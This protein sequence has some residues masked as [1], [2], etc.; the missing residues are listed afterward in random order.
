MV[1]K[2]KREKKYLQVVVENWWWYEEIGWNGW[3]ENGSSKSLPPKI[4]CFQPFQREEAERGKGF[5]GTKL[6]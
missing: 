1:G 5:K 6:K 3:T 4:W 2:K